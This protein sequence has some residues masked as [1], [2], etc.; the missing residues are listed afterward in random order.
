MRER[1]LRRGI[2]LFVVLLGAMALAAGAV[3]G[4]TELSI[5][6]HYW[7]Y[8]PALIAAAVCGIVVAGGVV[9]VRGA[10]RN[11]VIVRNPAP[12]SP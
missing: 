3:V 6:Y 1:R 12:R 11:R 2:R 10:L 9:L 5:A 4:A 7:P 8:W